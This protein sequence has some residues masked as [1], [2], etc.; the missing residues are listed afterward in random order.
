MRESLC[1]LASTL[2]QDEQQQNQHTSKKREHTYQPKL[3]SSIIGGTTH[4]FV[5]LNYSIVLKTTSSTKI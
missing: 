3:S 5:T 4:N 2:L 1:T